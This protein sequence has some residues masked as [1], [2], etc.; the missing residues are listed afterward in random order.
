M[1]VRILFP[2]LLCAAL[3]GCLTHMTAKEDTR[4]LMVRWEDDFDAACRTAAANGKPILV[5]MVAGALREK[6]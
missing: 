1:K 6:C 5:V 4:C 3:S 2:A